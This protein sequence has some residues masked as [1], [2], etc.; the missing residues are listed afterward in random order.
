[1][2]TLRS[3]AAWLGGACAAMVAAAAP[4]AGAQGPAQPTAP[5]PVASGD[6]YPATLQFGT[7]LITIPVA[8]I[9]PNNT[10]VWLNT[11]GRYTP[12]F[13]NSPTKQG[14]ASLWNTNIAV[15]AHFLN[16]FS[17]GVAAYDQNVDYGFFGQ[18]QVLRENQGYQGVPA[19]SVGFRNL[20]NCKQEDRMLLACDVRPGADGYQRIVDERYKDFNTRPSLY[21]VATKDFALGGGTGQL[22]SSTAGVTLGWGNGL[23]GDDGGLGDQY[24]KRG[25]IAKGL[26]LGGRYVMHPTLNTSVSLMAE[27]D[28]WDFNAGIVGDWRGLTLGIYGSELEEGGREGAAEG[29]DLYNYAKVNIAVGYSGNIIGISR[30]VLL[31]TRITELTREQQR[32]QA[33][34]AARDR[35]IQG[36]E[37]A[38]RKAQAGELADIAGRRQALEAELEQEREAI[39]RANERLRDLQA[40]RTT[41][42]PPAPADPPRSNPPP[43]P[44]PSTTPPSTPP[45][46]PPAA[47]LQAT[48][49]ASSSAAPSL[50]AAAPPLP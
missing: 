15:D 35:R 36:L 43:N 46:A 18:V 25:Q 40:G 8:W 14:F 13:P 45:A 23:F 12:T 24:N 16:R 11:S 48:P 26:F 28:G 30:G 19:I 3:G 39:R 47:A 7:G 42:L 41:P 22:P 17:V 44:P 21:V 6:P 1:M 37:V 31:R 49:T 20:G 5:A 38:L 50:D 10:D 27:N 2:R 33:E 32:L 9:S 34:I 4:Q 29:F